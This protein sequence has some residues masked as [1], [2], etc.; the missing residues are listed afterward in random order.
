MKKGSG[1]AKAQGK[2]MQGPQGAEPCDT[3]EQQKDWDIGLEGETGQGK[4]E[5]LRTDSTGVWQIAGAF[6]RSPLGRRH[7]DGGQCE[8]AMVGLYIS[9]A[10]V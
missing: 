1:E 6:L 4:M 10:V 9:M 3:S 5:S 8:Q 2:H 7:L